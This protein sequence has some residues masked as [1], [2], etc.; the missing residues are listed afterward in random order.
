MRYITVMFTNCFSAL[1]R[2]QLV[3]IEVIMALFAS[4]FNETTFYSSHNKKSI[5]LC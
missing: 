5:A 2:K 3:E 4:N 1:T